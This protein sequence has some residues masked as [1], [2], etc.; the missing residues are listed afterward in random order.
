MDLTPILAVPALLVAGFPLAFAILRSPF[1]AV[2]FAPLMAALLS[3]VAVVL[4]LVVGGPLLLWIALVLATGAAG[5]WW[6]LRRPGESAPYGG[7]SHALLIALPLLPPCLMIFEPAVQWDAHS[8]WWLHAGYFANGSEYARAAIGSPAFVFSHTDYPPLASAPLAA[9]WSVVEPDFRTAQLVGAVVTASAVAMLV[10]LVRWALGR[11]SAR[12]A[13][14]LAIAVGLAT[15]SNVPYAVTGGLADALWSVSFAGAAVALLL[16]ADPLRRPVLPLLLLTVA[17]LSK[18]EGLI[19]VAGLTVLVTV[20]AGADLRRAALVW[21][22]VLAGGA[23][24]VLA[25]LLD[26][27]SDITNGTSGGRSG[28]VVERLQFTTAALWDVVGPV[29]LGAAVVALLGTLFLSGR[30]R[31][32]GLAADGWVWAAIGYYLVVLVGTYLTGP[33][34]IQWWLATSVQRVTLPVMLLAAVSLAGWVAVASCGDSRAESQPVLDQPCEPAMSGSA[35][36]A[37]G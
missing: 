28:A 18:N 15:W 31:A 3:T 13:W 11:V 35:P 23:W 19:A 33:N 24:A 7:W 30:R 14:A 1:L 6:L 12:V 26:A 17:A 32:A 34:E 36:T 37:T 27:Q 22:P 5:A 2:L 20:R 4:M 29:L 25:R 8:I 10:Y 16:G 9:V 21:L